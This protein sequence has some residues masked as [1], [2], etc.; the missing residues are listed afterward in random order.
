MFQPNHSLIA[1]DKITEFLKEALFYPCSGLDGTPVKFTGKYFQKFIY[2]DYSIDRDQFLQECMHPGF[3][4]YRMTEV[5]D[6]SVESVFGDSWEHVGKQL[7]ETVNNCDFDWSPQSAF[8][9]AAHFE[10]ID[11]FDDEH[12]PKQFDLWF[13]KCEA[14]TTYRAIYTRRGIKPKCVAHIR[15]GIAF[16]GNFSGYIRVLQK[17]LIENPDGPP[18]YILHDRIGGD[19]R[20]GDY[21]HLVQFYHTLARWTYQTLH[22]GF[23]HLTLKIRNNETCVDFPCRLPL[24]RGY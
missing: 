2:V 23:S 19:P 8:I 22:H 3:R 16:G 9:L 11:G 5:H 13:I 4:G 17:T 24:H 18:D 20:W 15:S 12:G 1:M 7:R 10:R 21:L 6:L 14:I